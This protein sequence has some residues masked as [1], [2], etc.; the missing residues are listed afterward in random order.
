[1]MY[2]RCFNKIGKAEYNANVIIQNF[3]KNVKIYTM[4]AGCGIVF[5]LVALMEKR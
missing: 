2:R 1:M 3:D 5:V 4:F